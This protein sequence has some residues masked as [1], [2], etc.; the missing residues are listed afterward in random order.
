MTTRCKIQSESNFSTPIALHERPVRPP[1]HVLLRAQTVSP[2]QMTE[3]YVV[4]SP[5]NPF[6]DMI[7]TT[8][9]PPPA[10]R[11]EIVMEEVFFFYSIPS[12]YT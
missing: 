10:S 3:H 5:N 12:N 2:T 7:N 9:A 1:R 11:M 6:L 8:A 4:L